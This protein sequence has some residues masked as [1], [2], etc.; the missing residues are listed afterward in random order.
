MPIDAHDHCT[1]PKDRSSSKRR[2]GRCCATASSLRARARPPRP[3]AWPPIFPDF[4]SPSKNSESKKSD[5]FLS[6]HNGPPC[7]LDL[8]SALCRVTATQGRI[9]GL[10][11]LSPTLPKAR[12]VASGLGGAATIGLTPRRRFSLCAQVHH[13]FTTPP[14]S[15]SQAS[16]C[17]SAPTSSHARRA[18]RCCRPCSSRRSRPFSAASAS[19]S[20][21]SRCPS[22]PQTLVQTAWIQR[23][24]PELRLCRAPRVV[25]HAAQRIILWSGAP[26]RA[27][28][29]RPSP[30]LHACCSSSL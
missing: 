7:L 24:R 9:F 27:Q 12:K 30:P 16:G 25:R 17:P 1:F 20:S 2:S 23:E 22:A 6:C 14:G 11:P 3:A 21:T 26:L 5:L 18:A 29:A 8:G 10:E 15:P 19:T 4:E 13:K 28:A